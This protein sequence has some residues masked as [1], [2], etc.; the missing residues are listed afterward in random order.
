MSKIAEYTIFGP[1]HEMMIELENNNAFLLS[2]LKKGREQAFDF[3]F[4]K[5]YKALCAQASAY[6]ND[7]DT[8]QSLVQEC[9]VNL[10]QRRQQAD[11]I[12]SLSAYL[13]VMVRNQCIDYL[14]KE[15][16]IEKAHQKEGMQDAPVDLA[17]HS[18][19]SREFEEK[20]VV[21][22][23]NL[24]DRCRVAFEYSRFEGLTYNEIAKKM[25]ISVK[26]VEALIS[27][28]LKVLRTDMKDYLPLF[29]LL[30]DSNLL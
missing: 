9:F 18:L 13:S 20:L 2:E 25:D 4:R 26:G 5:Y 23:M 11:S 7:F 22:L 27:R 6:L 30:F 24:P 28:A 10:W 15:K 17:D 16:V 3:I 21:A 8:V 1:Q 12:E 14:R 29:I 19:I